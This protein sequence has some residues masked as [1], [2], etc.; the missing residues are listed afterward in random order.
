MSFSLGSR[1]V[2]GLTGAAT[3]RAATSVDSCHLLKPLVPLLPPSG[4][5]D[6]RIVRNSQAFGQ[7]LFKR[8]V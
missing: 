5:G 1:D 8:F 4:E 6:R 7:T 2:A 3:A